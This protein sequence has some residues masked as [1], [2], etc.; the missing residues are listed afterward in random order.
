MIIVA[1]MWRLCLPVTYSQCNF[2]KENPCFSI[3]ISSQI[4]FFGYTITLF[5]AFTNS[6]NNIKYQ[7]YWSMTVAES[8][9]RC[10]ISLQSSCFEKHQAWLSDRPYNSQLILVMVHYIRLRIN[11]HYGGPLYLYFC[12]RTPLLLCS[13][14]SL[15]YPN[16]DLLNKTK[17]V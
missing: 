9:R 12:M 5:N 11:R 17:E 15:F 2:L 16:W 14:H 13:A 1:G 10:A 4:S 3:L 6:E 8:A 7:G